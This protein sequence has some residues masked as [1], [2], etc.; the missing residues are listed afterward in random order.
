MYYVQLFDWYVASI[1]VLVICTIEIVIIGWIYGLKN[2]VRDIEYMIN[3]KIHTIWQLCWKYI[4]PSILCFI[5]CISI[6]RMFDSSLSYNGVPYPQ[7]AIYLGWTY[8]FSSTCIIPIF[9]V[10]ILIKSKGSFL[11]RIIQALKPHKWEP[12]LESD[13]IM[14]KNYCNKK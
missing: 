13:K 14:W 10:Y 7:W 9:M 2:F 11:E 5:L 12:A 6:S 3:R 1:S 8:G 4:T